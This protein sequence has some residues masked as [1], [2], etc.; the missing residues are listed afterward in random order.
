MGG[1]VHSVITRR[2]FSF[3]GVT[4]GTLDVPLIRAIDVTDAKSI[5]VVVRVHAAT[6]LSATA[7]IAV[8]ARA[9]SLTSEEPDA[10]FT[11]TT[12]LGTTTL[13]NT[14]G[15]APALKVTSLTGPW[16]HMIRLFVRGTQPASPVTLNATLSIDLVVRDT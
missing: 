15:S 13:D 1:V 5:D 4:T 10:D 16:G 7:T 8:H 3:T 2:Q 6:G 11:N 9:I 12:E 14:L